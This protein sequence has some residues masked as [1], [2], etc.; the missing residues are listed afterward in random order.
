MV[1]SSLFD[2]ILHCS[3]ELLDCR[4]FL[5]FRPRFFV[6]MWLTHYTLGAKN[7]FTTKIHSYHSHLPFLQSLILSILQTFPFIRR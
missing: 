4:M 1:L 7:F 3:L 6:V 5:S 2:Y